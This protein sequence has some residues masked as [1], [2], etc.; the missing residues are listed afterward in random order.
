[1][2]V[3]MPSMHNALQAHVLLLS[4]SIAHAEGFWVPGA[5]PR[6]DHN[7]GDLVGDGAENFTFPRIIDGA[8]A[9]ANKVWRIL[10]RLSP[11][12]PLRMTFRELADKWTGGDNAAAWCDAVCDDLCVY[13]ETTL[14]AWF[15]AEPAEISASSEANQPPL[16]PAQQ[17]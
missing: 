1:M 7:P 11:A 8:D 15:L 6:R 13:P 5:R 16:P 4:M 12:Y 9:L 3:T 10:L 2:G 17:T 14:E